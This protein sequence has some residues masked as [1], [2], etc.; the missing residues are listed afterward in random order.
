MDI[1][2]I[3]LFIVIIVLA[4]L[5]LALGVQVFFILREF[6]K[7]VFKANKVLDNT[8]VITESVSAPLSSLS[9]LASGLKT[10]TPILG[11]FK[12]IISKDDSG[13]KNKRDSDE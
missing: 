3:A 4:V 12:K 10:I 8:N 6:R 11:F 7:T 1:A 9:G 5:L 13:K 2:Q